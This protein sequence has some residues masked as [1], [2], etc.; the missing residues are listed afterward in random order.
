MC[1]RTGPGIS[2]SAPTN[3]SIGSIPSRKPRPASRSTTRVP[4]GP[5]GPVSHVSQDRAGIL[6][7]ATETGLHRLD[8]ASG[9]FRHYSHD[10]ADPGSLSSSLVRS[11]YEDREGTL[12]VCSGGSG[13]LR[14]A[15]GK[16][17]GADPPE[18]AR[19]A[20]GQGCSRT[21]RACCGS[22]TCP[23]TDWRPRIAIH[24][25][26]RS[27]RSRTASRPPHSS[28]GRRE[29]T[30]T[31]MATC[32]WR[33]RGSGLVKIDPEPAERGPIPPLRR[34]SRTASARTC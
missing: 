32:G 13:R 33:R 31:P 21:T 12:W 29:S 11:T 5:R 8:P 26:S 9:A 14:P 3:L 19:V 30:K 16:S 25:G 1:S 10:P 15:R 34:R 20:L 28:A 18:R 6:W 24:G 22:S 7:L 17:D 27:I 4:A 23:A 2:G